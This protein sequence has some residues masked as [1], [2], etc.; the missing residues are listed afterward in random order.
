MPEQCKLWHLRCEFER[1]LLDLRLFLGPRR[2]GNGVGLPVGHV[3]QPG[4]DITQ[5]VEGIDLQSPAVLDDCKKNRAALP[6]LGLANKQPVL[7]S[8]RGGP[9]RIL[10][11]IMPRPGLCREA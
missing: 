2:R 8:Y 5:V 3:R 9:D 10:D 6:R 4:Q 7:L 1:R 11:Q